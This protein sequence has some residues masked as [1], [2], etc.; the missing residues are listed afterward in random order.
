MVDD[1]EYFSYEGSTTAPPC[2]KSVTW[3]VLAEPLDISASDLDALR[4]LVPGTSNNARSTFPSA[5][6]N[7]FHYAVVNETGITYTSEETFAGLK[8]DWRKVTID[9]AVDVVLFA[10]GSGCGGFEL[11]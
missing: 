11:V 7:V 8:R 5:G 10:V 6:R 2:D 4:D 9:W 3:Y 1:T